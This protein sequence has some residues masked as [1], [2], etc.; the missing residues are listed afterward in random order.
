[1][2]KEKK[3]ILLYFTFY[4]FLSIGWGIYI[5]KTTTCGSLGLFC[6]APLM[7]INRLFILGVWMIPLGIILYLIGYYKISK[8]GQRE[9]VSSF[10][11]IRLIYILLLSLGLM[12]LAGG[13]IISILWPVSIVAL[14]IAFIL[15]YSYNKK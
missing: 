12:G 7:I 3:F 10:S 13:L 2:K 5:D 6:G 15:K 9:A 14:I 1:M 4:I 8:N 11:L